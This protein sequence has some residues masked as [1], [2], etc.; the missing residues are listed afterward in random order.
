[1]KLQ[2]N[3]NFFFS[4]RTTLLHE[5]FEMVRRV[6]RR[7]K[8]RRKKRLERQAE[9]ARREAE[10]E[11]QEALRVLA[12]HRQERTGQGYSGFNSQFAYGR[13]QAGHSGFNRRFAYGPGFNGRFG[14]N[15]NNFYK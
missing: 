10:Q 4:F 1:M 6:H 14:G 12:A 8:D 11:R 2:Y 7:A 13:A 9:Q 5:H 15:G 3:K